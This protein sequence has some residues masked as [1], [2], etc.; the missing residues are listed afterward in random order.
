MCN[1]SSCFEDG[2]RLRCQP[3]KS[4]RR[5]IFTLLKYLKFLIFKAQCK[6]ARNKICVLCVCKTKSQRKNVGVLK[7]TPP[8]S[9]SSS[10]S[11]CCCSCFK[12]PMTLSLQFSNFFFAKHK[13]LC[14]ENLFFLR[15][16]L[17]KPKRGRV[18]SL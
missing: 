12:W 18:R 9:S 2:A 1:F 17:Q 3:A 10:S 6:V 13:I 14:E 15:K 4:N 16:Y 7:H 5:K 8:P 11:C